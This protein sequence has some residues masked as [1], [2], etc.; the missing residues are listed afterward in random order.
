VPHTVLLKN[1]CYME[2]I[3]LHG[4]E[5]YT[6]IHSS[7]LLTLKHQQICISNSGEGIVGGGE[8]WE[9]TCV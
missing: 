9:C 6:Q 1:V 2:W 5:S 3:H 8:G 7:P 4:E